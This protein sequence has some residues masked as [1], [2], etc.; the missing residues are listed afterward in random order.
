MFRR[1]AFISIL[2]SIKAIASVDIGSDISGE[3]KIGKSLLSKAR[4]LENADDAEVDMSW[5]ARYSIKFHSCH[6]IDAFG[7]EENGGQ[8]EGQSPVGDKHLVHF[9]LC[10]TKSCSAGSSKKKNYCGDYVIELREFVESF[11]EFKEEEKEQECEAA[12]E[13]CE[14]YNCNVDDD[15]ACENKCLASKGF[16]YCIEDENEEEF[17][18]GEFLECREAEFGNNNNNNNNNNNA[19]YY[20]GPYCSNSGSSIHLGVF[21]DS[22]CSI[23]AKSNV[24]ETYNYGATLPYSKDSIVDNKCHSCMEVDDND[25]DNGN[26][27]YY[28][29]ELIQLCEENY[30]QSAKCETNV[31]DLDE[32]TKNEFSCTYINSVIPAME[33]VH[34][35]QGK[36]GAAATAFAWIFFFSTIGAAAFAYTLHQKVQRASVQL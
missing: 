7:G 32:N 10:P 1:L 13:A 12:M 31:A 27:Q 35:R 9:Q 36:S 3:S 8:E 24:Y 19:L 2:A 29:A 33:N 6:T 23:Q 25:D 22:S 34:F 16:D 20:M 26:D 11:A 4:K 18:L 5:I 28:D 30:E 14:Y 15:E 17:D 21:T